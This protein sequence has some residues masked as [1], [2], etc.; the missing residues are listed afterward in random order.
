M[1]GVLVNTNLIDGNGNCYFGQ[2]QN[3]NHYI[4]A[5]PASGNY[6]P[7]EGQVAMQRYAVCLLYNI[8]TRQRQIFTALFLQHSL[9]NQP[10]DTRHILN[11]Y[12]LPKSP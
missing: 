1:S 5:I 12:F 10:Y 4:V 2:K 9:S 8:L 11:T 6:I 7:K 3:A